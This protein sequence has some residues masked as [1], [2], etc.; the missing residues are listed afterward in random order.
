[1]KKI[2]ILIMPLLI[3]S[4]ENPKHDCGFACTH[5]N[6]IAIG[7][8]VLPGHDFSLGFHAHYIKGVALDNRLGL[9]LGF[10]TIL[11]DETHNA[12]NLMSVYRFGSKINGYLS[13]AY[14]VGIL[15]SSEHS[16]EEDHHHDEHGNEVT[17]SFVQHLEFV[18]E[19]NHRQQMCYGP[20]LDVGFEK[21]EIHYMIGLHVGYIF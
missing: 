4:Q 8:G 20:V 19:I 1:M 21:G 7:L 12:Y 14:G 3:F 9:G 11:D 17:S 16:H 6:E 5:D 10:E 18:Y 15:R 2:F 13:V